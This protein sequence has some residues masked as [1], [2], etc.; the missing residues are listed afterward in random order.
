[1]FFFSI[2]STVLPRVSTHR[3]LHRM[4]IP[5]VH[6]TIRLRWDVPPTRLP[7]KWQAWSHQRW[8]NHQTVII[9]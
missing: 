6:H 1:V 9:A 8:S 3:L 5:S 7:A 2:N 4:T